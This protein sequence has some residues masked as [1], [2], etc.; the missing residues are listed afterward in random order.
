MAIEGLHNIIGIRPVSKEEKPG[1]NQG[2]KKKK[3][4]KKQEDKDNEHQTNRKGR[5]DIRI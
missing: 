3:D 4:S 2:R 5:I 1:Q